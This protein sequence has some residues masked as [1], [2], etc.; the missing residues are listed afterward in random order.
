MIPTGFEVNFDG[1]VGPT[2]NYSG[3][4]YGN[5]ASL[6]HRYVV[7]NPKAAAMQGLEKMKF[8][9]DLGIKQAVLPPHE[10][11][12]LP[13]L[14][15]L[16]FTG[17]DRTIP[18]KA[19]KVE[20]LFLY[21]FSSASSMWVANA[22]TV[23]PSIDC[24]DKKVHFTPAN[25]ATMSHRTIE[26]AMTAKILKA[27]FPRSLYFMHHDPLPYSSYFNDEGSANH[28][29]FCR[30][31]TETGVH[32][33]VYGSNSLTEEEIAPQKFPAR[34]TIQASEA[35]VRAHQLHPERVIFAQQS[36]IAIDAG[37]FHND[38]IAVGD[39]NLLFYHEDAFEDKEMLI[40]DIRS[41][42]EEHCDIEMQFIEVPSSKISL[43]VAIR[44]YLFNSQLIS[45][46]DESFS[47]IA[48]IECQKNAN[49]YLFLDKL[50]K[51]PDVPIRDLHFF[52]LR[53]SMRNGGGPACLRLRVVL[54]QN[55]LNAVNP[56]VFITNKLYPKLTAWVEKHYRDHLEPGDLA[57]PSL[58]DETQTA[59][60]ELTRILDLGHIYSFQR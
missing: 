9:A 4:S 47:L 37:A 38:V 23:S 13:T 51:D 32:L 5:I 50:T 59:L 42:V 17:P 24:V 14:R 25:L 27:I 54:T 26:T 18:G 56:N 55:E 31:Y 58:V 10:R 15:A 8:L 21:N 53:E 6:E 29:R 45:L 3:L 12:H 41:K 40:D 28:T 11:P 30:S 52:N 60:D 43:K 22:A 48:P 35:I 1:I 34:Q 20:P 49:V 57:D 44:T 2:H 7:S 36:P 19:F 39:R 46:P 16:G 33:F